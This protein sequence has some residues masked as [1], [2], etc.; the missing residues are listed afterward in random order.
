MN[1]PTH[2][3]HYWIAEG[4]GELS[5]RWFNPACNPKVRRHITDFRADDT[6]H[7]GARC[8]DCLAITAA[9]DQQAAAAVAAMERKAQ[10]SRTPVQSD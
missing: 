5:S 2:P 3:K 8:P 1:E 6:T 4:N 7:D 10:A 9:M